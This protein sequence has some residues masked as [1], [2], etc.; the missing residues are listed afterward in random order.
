MDRTMSYIRTVTGDIDPAQ[1]G[2]TL[3]H[4]HVLTMPP[5]SVKDRDLELSDENVMKR[6]L[7]HLYSAGG[8]AL[9]EMSPADYGRSPQG[10]RRLSEVSGVKIIAVTGWIKESSYSQWSTGRT[11][12]Q[13]ADE[14]IADI[15]QGMDGTP[16]KAGVLKAGSSKNKITKEEEKV[17]KAAAIAHKETNA[18]VSTHTEAGTMGLE[19]VELLKAGGV[20]AERILIGHCDRNLD[21]DYHLALAK[22]GVT[23]GFDQISK[24]KY[25][26]D[27]ER[28]RFIKRLVKAGYAN[29]IA[30]SGDLARQS[31]FPEYGGWQG[32][33]YTYVLWR[34]AAWLREE[35]VD[36]DTITC[37]FVDTPR[38]L[39][40]I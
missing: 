18:A 30:L 21:W 31:Y 24:E 8:R 15:Q 39:L 3:M 36:A 12:R 19:Q 23:L 10:L 5:L 20:P 16:V 37:M 38:R 22:T 35:G 25:Y 27:S 11:K 32:P 2:I 29:Q 13:I 34:F 4:E 1:L 40:T 14:M 9:V 6:E 33:G 17:F 7:Q 26:P 28:I